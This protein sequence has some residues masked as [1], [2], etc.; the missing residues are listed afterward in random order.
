MLTISTVI[1]PVSYPIIASTMKRQDVKIYFDERDADVYLNAVPV[2][3]KVDFILVSKMLLITPKLGNK[4]AVWKKGSANDLLLQLLLKLYSL[5]PE[6]VYVDNPNEVYKLYS[7]GEVDSAMVTVGMASEGLYVEDL[8]KN[9]GFNI[10]GICGAKVIR[11]GDDFEPAYQEGIDLFKENP[12][13]VSEY[14]MDNLPIMRPSTFIR[15]IMET[16]VYEVKKVDFDF[17]AFKERVLSSFN[18]TPLNDKGR[19]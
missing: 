1:G 11:N 7:S 4:I 10:P 15:K 12:E 17:E 8:F 16:A 14:I 13:E 19:D 9:K 6:V 5:N 2:L 3:G 18:E